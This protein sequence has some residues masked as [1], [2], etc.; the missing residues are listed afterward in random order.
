M[1]RLWGGSEAVEAAQA[2]DAASVQRAVARRGDSSGQEV[3]PQVRSTLLRY[4]DLAQHLKRLR[5]SP[6][7]SDQ[8]ALQTAT[9][10][11]QNERRLSSQA[12]RPAVLSSSSQATR[13]AV[14]SSARVSKGSNVVA[15]CV[16]C[17]QHRP[18]SRRRAGHV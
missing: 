12:T 1:L 4:T 16:V 2:G 11:L 15:L 5:G 7:S 3:T 8:T 9:Q 6:Q 18:R 13:P 10:R 14:L 17:A